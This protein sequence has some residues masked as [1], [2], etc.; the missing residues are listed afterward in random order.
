MHIPFAVSQADTPVELTVRD[1]LGRTV[2]TLAVGPAA[3]GRH[4]LRWDGR[5]DAGEPV[6]NGAYLV[7]LRAGDRGAA[8]KVMLIK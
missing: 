6:G 3:A 5:D 8:G 7:H 4:V 1:L 2:R